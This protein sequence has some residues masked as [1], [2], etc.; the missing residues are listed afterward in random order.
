[1]SGPVDLL[2]QLDA[3]R[4][5]ATPG[6]WAVHPSDASEVV[7]MWKSDE[8]GGDGW[9][10][11]DVCGARTPIPGTVHGDSAAEDANAALIVAA[12]N[13]VPA[14]TSALRAVADVREQMDAWRQNAHRYGQMHPDEADVARARELA[15]QRAVDSLD[16]ALAALGG[17]DSGNEQ[18]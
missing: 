1:M 8:D 18:P 7:G 5:A 6:P 10:G 3:L 9:E 14:L 16:A 15:Y 11:I 12:V 4:E 17:T 2:D 13:A